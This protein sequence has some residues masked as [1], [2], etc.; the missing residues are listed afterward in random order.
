MPLRLVSN[1]LNFCFSAPPHRFQIYAVSPGVFSSCA[2]NANLASYIFS[3]GSCRLGSVHLLLFPSLACREDETPATP[4][5]DDV[6]SEEADGGQRF[7]FERHERARR[8]VLLPHMGLP[9]PLP[10]KAQ[11]SPDAAAGPHKICSASVRFR[12]Y[13]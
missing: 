5:G 1:A 6:T 12:G 10:S 3:R 8:A 11:R 13:R 7:K 9:V 2:A 4:D